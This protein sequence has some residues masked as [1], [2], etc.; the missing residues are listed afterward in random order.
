[1]EENLLLH[2]SVIFPPT[3]SALNGTDQFE[4]ICLGKTDEFL[5]TFFHK[6]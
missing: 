1:M 4:A 2:A 3:A 5:K 6:L